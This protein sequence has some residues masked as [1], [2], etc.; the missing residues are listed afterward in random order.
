VPFVGEWKT[1]TKWT[2]NELAR[3]LSDAPTQ[4][5]S[6]G[7]FP[8]GPVQY[9]VPSGRT[10]KSLDDGDVCP[11]CG[12]LPIYT[13]SQPKS[14]C[15]NCGSPLIDIWFE[16]DESGHALDMFDPE[17]DIPEMYSDND[18]FEGEF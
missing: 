5:S 3:A 9:N 12:E 16:D 8:S 1:E 11:F 6:R 4:I 18:F 14:P 10:L 13:D 2:L 7:F 15:V 17:T